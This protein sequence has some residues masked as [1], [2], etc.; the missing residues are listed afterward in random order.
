MSSPRRDPPDLFDETLCALQSEHETSTREI[1]ALVEFQERMNSILSSANGASHPTVQTTGTTTLTSTP[2]AV[3]SRAEDPRSRLQVA[4]SETVMAAPAASE[5][6]ENIREHMAAEFGADTAEAV[7]SCSGPPPNLTPVLSKR[8]ETA[9]EARRGMIQHIQ[10]EIEAVEALFSSLLN[11]HETVTSYQP[12]DSTSFEEL[13]EHD[14]R[15]AGFTTTCN[16]MASQRQEYLQSEALPD[17]SRYE[18]TKYFYRDCPFA[19]PVLLAI[20]EIAHDIRV[21]RRNIACHVSNC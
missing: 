12:T 2:I 20:A 7:F 13:V 14:E 4:Y 5:L 17:V 8:I 1:D 3:S 9:I 21:L 6:E 10:V 11:L 16:R 19:F 18:L 15:F